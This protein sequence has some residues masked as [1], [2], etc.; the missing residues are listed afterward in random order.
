[1]SA[2][3]AQFFRYLWFM[4]SLGVRSPWSEQNQIR[5]RAEIKFGS[6]LRYW[7]CLN[8]FTSVVT[9]SGKIGWRHLWTSHLCFFMQIL[10]CLVMHFSEMSL[11][12]CISYV[13]V[14]MYFWI[15]HWWVG[16]VWYSTNAKMFKRNCKMCEVHITA[17]AFTLSTRVLYCTTVWHIFSSHI[18][19]FVDHTFLDQFSGP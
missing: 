14:R 9:K 13:K 4:P 18:F 15:Y 11:F 16:G 8:D 10:P 7:N 12:V 6:L 5:R 1:M 2:R 17:N 3:S 19:I